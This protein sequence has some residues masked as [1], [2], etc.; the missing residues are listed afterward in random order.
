MV[1]GQN[2]PKVSIGLYNPTAT[3]SAASGSSDLALMQGFFN[4][5]S[6]TWVGA[7]GDPSNTSG[8]IGGTTW[9]GIANYIQAQAVLP[10]ASSSSTFVTNFNPGVGQLYAV[11]GQVLATGEWNNLSL[12]DIMPTWRWL[13][14]STDGGSTKLTPNF[15]FTQAYYG[16][17]SLSVTGNMTAYNNL[18][19]YATQLAVSSSSN[20]EIVFKNGQAGAATMMQVALTFSDSSV[21]Y[22][23]CG[24][25]T[26]AGWNTVTF[27]LASYAGKTITGI[28]LEFGNGAAVNNYTMNIGQVL[29]YS[30]SQSTPAAPTNLQ[31]LATYDVSSN[32][33][34]MRLAWTHA[35]GALNAGGDPTGMVYAYNIFQLSGGSLSFL[36]ADAEQR[37]FRA[38]DSPKRHFELCRDRSANRGRR[39]GDVALLDANHV[40]RLAAAGMDL[41]LARRRLR[42]AGR[43]RH[44][45]RVRADLAPR[46]RRQRHR[47]R[48][49][50]QQLGRYG[51]LQRRHRGHRDRLRLA[52][53]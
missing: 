49:L 30:G 34:T 3:F 45:E 1:S 8:T 25:T 28:G 2:T 29:I 48:A 52:S 26:T 19:L 37:L 35:A 33:A 43:Q 23:S 5:E 22:L 15:D 21:G 44:L 16:G 18:S 32:T 51:R 50:E 17:A 9:T 12:Q 10:S 14:T 7:K 46:R 39:H 11:N 41:D 38:V 53:R 4:N 6:L 42:L 36:G 13:N 24:T 40:R 31:E 27:N 20:L 47:R